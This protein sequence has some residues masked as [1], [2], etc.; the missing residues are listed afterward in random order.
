MRIGSGS[1]SD[2]QALGQCGQKNSESAALV[3]NQM[4]WREYPVRYAAHDHLDR[5]RVTLLA[6]ARSGPD[7]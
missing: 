2:F 5:Q 4:L 1:R 7:G 3:V 6:R